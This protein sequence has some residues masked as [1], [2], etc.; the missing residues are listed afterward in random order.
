MR[1]VVQ[2]LNDRPDREPAVLTVC[3]SGRP[4]DVSTR[5]L[6]TPNRARHLFDGMRGLCSTLATIFPPW[7]LAP[8]VLAAQPESVRRPSYNVLVSD[9]ST[10]HRKS[11]ISSTHA[12]QATFGPRGS[13]GK[14]TMC[15]NRARGLATLTLDVLTENACK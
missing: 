4:V 12:Q 14:P 13:T 5:R 7:R 6:L 1:V 10:P 11:H 9:Q 15:L 2:G 8:A 3:S